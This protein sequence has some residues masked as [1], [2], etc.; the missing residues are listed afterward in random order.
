MGAFGL[1]G[2][3][4]TQE[5]H[6]Q[7]L[8]ISYFLTST[9]KSATASVILSLICCLVLAMALMVGANAMDPM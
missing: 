9:F 7:S 1:L 5:Y 3:T 6:K 8:S 4:D 2:H